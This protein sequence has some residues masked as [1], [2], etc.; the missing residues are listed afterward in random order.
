MAR[1]KDDGL[2][3]PSMGMGKVMPKVRSLCGVCPA[4][5]RGVAGKA[6]SVDL[7]MYMYVLRIQ[8]DVCVLA[9]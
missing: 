6:A 7:T 1:G 8:L 2:P 4:Q 3:V 5:A 9:T